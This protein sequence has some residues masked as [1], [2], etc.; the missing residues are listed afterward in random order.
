MKKFDK[1]EIKWE[2]SMHN[3]GWKAENDFQTEYQDIL[4]KTIGYFLKETKYSIIV[5]QSYGLKEYDGGHNI[6]SIMEIPKKS[7]IKKR[8]F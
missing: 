2:D 5:V 4:H 7:I 3:N 8:K 1:I 6:D